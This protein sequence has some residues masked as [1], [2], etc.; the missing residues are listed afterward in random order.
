[1]S[2]H[3][4]T[5]SPT[6]TS[7]QIAGQINGNPN[8]GANDAAKIIVNQVNSNSPSQL[9]GY[10]EVAGARTAAVVIANSSGLVVDGGGFINTSKGI[11]T[12]GNPIIDSGGNL[13]GFNVTSGT[14]TLQGAGLNASNIDEVD[15]LSRAVQANAAIYGNTLHV[16]TGSN[17]IDY[18]SLNPTPIAGSGPAPG[19]S[20]DVAQL[21]GMYANRII[22]VG[23]ENGVGVANAGTIAAQAGDL[24]LTTAGQLVQSGKMNASG[25]I[26][27][28]AAGIANT[29]TIYGQQNSTIS[30]S[31]ALTNGGTIASQ[32]NT[33]INAAS[34][35]SSGLLGAGINPDST[36]GTGGSLSVT[37][38]GLLSATGQT[39][40]PGTVSLYGVTLDLSGAQVSAGGALALTATG[41]NMGL[42]GAN[43]TAGTSF[44][45]DSAGTLDSGNAKLGSGAAMQL[46][47]AQITNAGGQ[48]VAGT[49]LNVQTAGAL[50]NLQGILQ[51]AGQ[52]TIEAGSVDNTEGKILSLNADGLTVNASGALVNGAGGVIGGNGNVS[53]SAGSISNAGQFSA[54]GN[55]AL[56][57]QSI[58]N[59]GGSASA[60]GALSAQASGALSNIGGQFSATDVSLSGASIDNTSGQI[61][62]TQVSVLTPGDLLNRKGTIEQSGTADQTVSAGGTLD[63]TGGTI[64]TNAQNLTVSGGNIVNDDGEIQHAGTGALDVAATNAISNANGS[65][66]TNGALR[67]SA[68]SLAN[69]GRILAVGNATLRNT[70]LDNHAGSILAG[71]ALNALTIGAMNN[72]GGALNGVATSV[73]GSSIEN[74]NGGQ[75]VG[76]TVA[77]SAS[78]DLNN[79]GGTI[80]QSGTADQTIN[81]G[82][83]FENAGGTVGSNATNLTLSGASIDNDG[84]AVSHAGTGTLAI[85]TPGVLSSVA[86]QI[87]TNGALNLQSASLDNTG[88]VLSAEQSANVSAVSG[89]ANA[90]GGQIYGNTGLAATTQGDFNNAG[91]SAQSGGN[92]VI[93]AGGALGNANGVISANGAVGTLAVTASSVDNTSGTL[94][95]S[96]SGKTTIAATSDIANTGG[97]MGGN[98]DVEIDAKTLKNNA[99]AQLVAAGAADL[100]VTGQVDNTNGLA[101]GGTSLNLDQAGVALVNGSGKIEGGKD[102]SLQVASMSNGGGAV[103]ANHD[104][105]MSGALSGGGSMTAG[106]NLSVTLPGDYTNDGTSSFNADNNLTFTLPGTLSNNS[107]LEAANALTVN[108]GKVVNGANAHM[109]SATTTVNAAN[110]INN[111]GVIE[112]NNVTT[113]SSTLENTGALI[114]NNVVVNAGDVTNNGAQAVIAGATFV[115]V[116]ASN[117]ITNENGALIYS[118]GN[119]ELA[120]DNARDSTGLLADQTG[121]IENSAST[122]EATGNIDVAAHTLNNDRTGVQTQAG[123][124]VTTTGSTLTLWTAGIPI[125]ELGSYESVTYPQWYFKAGAVGTESI[126]VLSKPLTV[127]LPASQV[128]NINS[129]NQTFSLTTALTDTYY[130]DLYCPD[131]TPQTRTITNNPTQYYQSLTQNANGTVTISFYPDYNPNVNIN[132]AQVQ[133][134]YDLGT[135]SHDYVELSRTVTTTTSTDQLLNAGTAA[136]MQAQG[137]IRINSD[138]GAINNNSSTMAAGGDLVRRATGGSVNDNGVVL[139]QTGSETD[140]SVFYWH[141]KTGGSNDTQTVNDTAVPL[142]TTTVAALPAI[143]TSNQTVETDAENIN[144]GSVN[145]VGQ[146]VTGAGVAGGDAT[147]MQLDSVSGAGSGPQASASVVSNGKRPQTLGSAGV[148]IPGL[149]LPKNALYSYNTAPG[150]EYLVETNSRFT[151]YTQF[152]SSDY[153]LNALGLDPQNVE[154]RLGDGMYEEQLVMNQVTQLTGRTFLGSYTD[155][156]DEYTALMNNGV[157]YAQSFGLSVGVALTP[158]QM[159]EL[160]TDMVWLVNQTVTLPDGT[161]Q[162]VLVPQLYLAQSNTVDLQDSGALVAGK[163]VDLNATGDVTNSGHVAGDV[164][165]TVIGNNVVNRGVI[166]SGGTTTVQA[167]QDVSNLGGRIGGVDT[168]VT[169]GNDIINQSTVAQAAVTTGNAGFSSTATGMAVQSVGTISA[170]NS[171]TLIAGHDVDLTGSAIQTGGD[172][173]IA[174]GHDINVGTTTLTA[175]QDAGMTDG[176][177]FGHATA[178][179]NVGSTITAGGNLTT[180]SGNDTT[181]T[182]AKVQAGGDATMV[183][184][185]NLTVTAAKDAATYN[186]QSMGGKISEHKDSTYDESVQGSSI[187][188]GGN[189]TLAAG[190]GSTGNLSVL[191]SS[192]TTGG[193]NGAT[194]GAV[195]LQST[196]DINVGSVAGEHDASHWSHTNESGFLSSAKTTDSSTSQQSIAQGSTVSGN[197]VAAN[198]SHDLT[199]AGSTVASTGDMSLA[200][201]H[202]LTVT[203]TQDTSQS[204]TFHEEQKSGFGALSGGGASINY[205]TSDQKTTTHDSSVT[206]NGSLVGSTGGSVSMT[207]G[208][209]LTVTGSDV[210]AAQNVTG[211]A[212]NVTINAATDTS[213]HDETQEMHQSGFTLGLGG[214]VGDAIN[215]AVAQGQ[216]IASGNSDGRATALHAIALGG[217]A[218]MAGVGAAGVMGGAS[219]PNAPSIS[220]QLSF[221]SSQSKSTFTEDQ[222]TQK[223]STV[224]AGG[225]AAFVA[226]GNGTPGSGNVTIA[227]SNVSANDVLLAAKNQVN[228]VNTTNTDTTA[229]TN[230][231]SSASVGV[232]YGTQGFGVSASMSNAHGDANS[233]AAIQNNSH[234]TGANSVTISSGGDTNVIGSDVSG[235]QVTANVGGNLNVKSVQD[236]TVSTAHQSS[237]SGGFSISQGGGS[238]SFSAQN[239][240]ADSN[241]AQVNEQA[242]IQAGSGGF[243]INVKGNT[244]LTGAVISSTADP[245]Q[246]N[247]TTGT[248]TFSNIENKSH[249]SAASNG[250]SAG[251][252]VGNTGKATGPGSVSGTGGVVP[253]ISQDS[254]GDSSATTL[255]AISTGTINITN[256]SVQTQDVLGLSHDTTNTN[257]TVANTPNLN[258]LLSQQADT[259]QAAQAAGQVVAQGIG[260]YADSKRDAALKAAQTAVDNGDPDAASAALADY[261]NWK[262]GGNLRAELQ[263]A[264]GALIGGLGGGGVFTTIGGAAG[265][266]LS[267]KLADQTQSV[268]DSVAGATG[269]TIIGNVTGNIL[270]NLAGAL[271]GGSAGA[272]AASNVDLYNQTMDTKNKAANAKA[273]SL[274]QQAAD[275]YNEIQQGR[276]AVKNTISSTVSG[277]I[278]QIKAHNGQNPPADPNPLVQ[279]NDGGN[280][281]SGTAGAVVT[282][283]VVACGPGGAC[284]VSPPVA[285][286][287]ASGGTPSNATLS[288]GDDNGGAN[289]G[290]GNAPTQPVSNPSGAARAA[291]NSGNWSSGSLSETVANIAGPNPEISYTNSGKTIYTNPTNGNSVVY[292]NAGNYYRVTN[293]AGQYLDQSGNP[294]PNNVPLVGANKTTQ[295]G[296]PSGIRQALTHYNNTDPKN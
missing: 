26:G 247:L 194:G 143:A 164:A 210:I 125:S 131:C 67:E 181:L 212:A 283:P 169:A 42:S 29:G 98:G 127:T 126:Q 236:T 218:A 280:T 60:G 235:K 213:H 20:I 228:I 83:A 45:V 271:V 168:V 268:S 102:V 109:N 286:P 91:G 56:V 226:T 68:A 53:L 22:L 12:T 256:K 46:T 293:A 4:P 113:K 94:T 190:Q 203:T 124:P 76:T 21:G 200:A 147:G 145:R 57:A 81:A 240:H 101:Y 295:T 93:T 100:K 178:T 146:T 202:D 209:N 265:A 84:G 37:S 2:R 292:D 120:R 79:S 284:V 182:D 225:T 289:N 25:N 10:V 251:V 214:S 288:S 157:Q 140:T 9:R 121:T 99:N 239:G 176:E 224:Q 88:G 39:M 152:V 74:G 220:V 24:T 129:G 35:A 177:A 30:S 5:N 36:T 40:A 137:A 49:T 106:N 278:G 69:Q 151:S 260:A 138:G 148:A 275:L 153:M 54:L 219:G 133:V 207:A 63:D 258:N 15:L 172:A 122:I 204:S 166:G 191:G 198:A 248:L 262:E 232:S 208:N 196:G 266:A 161:Q 291:A 192:V 189:A 154:K 185:G 132:P 111:A 150:A 195:S 70:T 17:S 245:S 117:S 205:G 238:A 64:A 47:A 156:L 50:D 180:V 62:G 95:N 249:Y 165:T 114:G 52:E 34:V 18:A 215:S 252:G 105:S 244:N 183:A 285:T 287:G 116:Y 216:A 119:M 264:G 267:S 230:K 6:I 229:S 139:Q 255:S 206:D 27:V 28:V 135:D 282:P 82:G 217:N 193:V 96:G 77:V 243:D 128:T 14:I 103:N 33:V 160:T 184:A 237:T 85:T 279:A 241:Y 71:G 78:G 7:T 163:D 254:N 118:G 227:G 273:E 270:A 134:R 141:Q 3:L 276:Q 274:T 19:V 23:N 89:I 75:I 115:G 92:I 246:N 174:A 55:A 110:D 13:T 281:P 51:A 31:G 269:S 108:A 136:L 123:T 294:M 201:G 73:S 233:D 44:T 171:A 1:M 197:T 11:L 41:G 188:A 242:G 234:V 16:V 261:N 144:I 263:A 253:M 107:V 149:V 162:T 59:N 43:A 61:D 155:N 72:E 86:G 259:M 173:T 272:A 223:G 112:G 38:A 277:V 97:V 90:N 290:A 179:H 186:G 80:Q 142:P 170:T 257:G 175:T 199:I 8:F 48:A 187:N 66:G 58:S 130:T 231:S 296:V 65:I 211:T 87:A 167:V 158:A 159:S 104:I 250:I 222:T 221:G 32:Q